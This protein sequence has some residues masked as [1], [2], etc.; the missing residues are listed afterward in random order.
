MKHST[1]S[2]NRAATVLI[3]GKPFEVVN[4]KELFAR[5]MEAPLERERSSLANN[6]DE[7]PMPACINFL[8]DESYST[9]HMAD[10]CAKLLAH[11]SGSSAP[12]T[13]MR[14]AYDELEFMTRN[15]GRLIVAFSDVKENNR[16]EPQDFAHPEAL[17]GL[18]QSDCYGVPFEE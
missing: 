11:F 2:T 12:E 3:N 10:I 17:L 1:S 13:E 18:D 6:R 4:E 15:L 8:C 7:D 5:F 9:D 14:E 16:L